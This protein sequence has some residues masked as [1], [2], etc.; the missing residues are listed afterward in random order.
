MANWPER[1]RR[2]GFLVAGAPIAAAIRPD[3][4]LSARQSHHTLDH[5]LQ[6]VKIVGFWQDDDIVEGLQLFIDG[7]GSLSRGDDDR[8]ARIKSPE[9]ADELLARQVGQAQI[10]ERHTDL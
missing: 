2:S 10:D 8:Q 7:A 3:G 1:Q 6:I 5:R 9:L 4:S